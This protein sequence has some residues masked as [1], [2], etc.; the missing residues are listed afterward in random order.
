MIALIIAAGVVVAL[1]LTLVRLFVGPTLYDR[2]L[3]ATGVILQAALLCAAFSVA[4][5]RWDLVD[6]A[7]ALTLA[8]FVLAVAILKYFRTRNF[9]A[10]MAPS[11][12]DWR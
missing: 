2:A 4:A 12:E 11:R 1:G 9:Q 5:N 8:A 6:A 10:A 3:S 7:L